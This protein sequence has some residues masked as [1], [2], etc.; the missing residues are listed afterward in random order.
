AAGLR[1]IPPSFYD[2][3][4]RALGSILPGRKRIGAA[5]TKAHRLAEFLPSTS[6]DDIY[7]RTLSHWDEPEQLVLGARE[8]LTVREKIAGAASLPS[9]E[10]RMMLTD[11]QVY[12]ADDILTKV[13][14]ASMAVSLEAR[15]PIL[16]HRVVEFAWKLPLRA[17]IRDGV[18]KWA[19]RQVLSK[20]VPAEFYERPK[21]GFAVPLEHWLR[22]PLRD[23][24]ESRLSEESL[25]SHQLLQPELVRS[26]WREH[27]SGRRNW[28][29][30]LWNVLVF[31]DWYAES[32]K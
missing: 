10:E 16:D 27:V 28:Q 29:Y 8:P 32:R 21:M 18:S 22:G 14:R 6:Q 15:V 7:R 17:K 23:W 30:L 2:H 1:G 9:F 26:K 24:A 11:Q 25:R 19:L 20:Y 12:L 31:Q 3:G 4:S 5:G 13:D